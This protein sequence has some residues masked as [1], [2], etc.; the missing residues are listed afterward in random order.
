MAVLSFAERERLYAEAAE[1]FRRAHQWTGSG[2]GDPGAELVEGMREWVDAVRKYAR[3]SAMP[4]P[5]KTGSEVVALPAAAP[6]PAP[7]AQP[8]AS[9]WR[10]EGCGVDNSAA[11]KQ[12]KAC[13]RPRTVAA[14]ELR[15]E[16]TG[17]EL[18]VEDGMRVGRA[19]YRSVFGL[20]EAGLAA[21]DQFEVV[22]DAGRGV[23]L[24]KPVPGASHPTCYQGA[25]VGTAGCELASEGVISVG[26]RLKLVVRF[27]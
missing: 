14:V 2:E 8:A 23:W 17:K 11:R 1:E 19:E 3:F 25:E 18:R 16:A 10:C 7:A 26:D 15:A 21:A 12:C 24:V 4:E 5:R 6:V 9:R 13:G 20:P 22:R 27:V